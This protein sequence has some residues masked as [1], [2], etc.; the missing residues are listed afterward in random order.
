M[1]NWLKNLF[2]ERVCKDYILQNKTYE[3]WINVQLKIIRKKEKEI[4]KLKVKKEIKVNDK[5]YWDSKWAQADIVY[6]APYRKTVTEYVKFRE[7]QEIT[8]IART[9]IQD[10]GLVKNAPDEVPLVVMEWL[11]KQFKAKK[12]KYIKEEKEYWDRP[13]EVLNKGSDC[14]GIGILEYYII[15]K[16]F[17]ELGIW[18]SMNH[19]LK[20]VAGNVNRKGNIPSNAGGHFYLIWLH[21]NGEFFTVET[22]YYLKDAIENYGIVSHKLNMLYGTLWFTFS[23]EKSW[24]QHSIIISKEDYK[25]LYTKLCFKKLL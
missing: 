20:C 7:I 17:Q 4:A 25:Y 14:D 23:S 12:L 22:T 13:E 3:D 10:G 9:I 19:R 8:E 24:A 21:N 16:I 6:A 11:Q 2:K 5:E 15:R 1:I 18:K